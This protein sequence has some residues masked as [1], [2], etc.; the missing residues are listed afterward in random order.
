MVLLLVFFSFLACSFFLVCIH[1]AVAWPFVL[2]A[3]V[4]DCASAFCAFVVLFINCCTQLDAFQH[5]VL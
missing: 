1:S 2:F 5:S 4:F 3:F